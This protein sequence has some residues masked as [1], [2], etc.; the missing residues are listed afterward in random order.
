MLVEAAFAKAALPLAIVDVPWEETGW[1][2]GPLKALNPLGQ[3]P[4]LVLPD[5]AVMTE[6][7]AILLHLTE[8][9]PHADL[10]PAPG[11][12]SRPHFLRWL[13]FL[14]GAIYPTSLTAT[15]RNA[16]CPA[17]RTRARRFPRQ[18]SNTARPCTATSRRTL[19]RPTSSARG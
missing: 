17:R 11:D 10:A 14:V 2:S 9:A 5:G 6:S 3:V 7:A 12:P 18:T 13:Q 15:A 1:E 8:I 4:T 19:A 16:G